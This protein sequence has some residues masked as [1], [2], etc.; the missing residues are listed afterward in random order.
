MAKLNTKDIDSLFE[1]EFVSIAFD[2]EKIN[3]D[4]R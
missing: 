4:I 1:K 3:F 2:S